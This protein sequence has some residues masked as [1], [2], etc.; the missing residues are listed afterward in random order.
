MIFITNQITVLCY[1]VSED[2]LSSN[3]SEEELTE[4]RQ[5]GLKQ[6]A[7]KRYGWTSVQ[8]EKEWSRREV[9]IEQAAWRHS[10]NP[11]CA[12]DS[13]FFVSKMQVTSSFSMALTLEHFPIQLSHFRARY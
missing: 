7:Q 4:P 6:R 2:E 13:L 12:G 3:G 9:A 10:Y 1:P 5:L 11:V 8:L